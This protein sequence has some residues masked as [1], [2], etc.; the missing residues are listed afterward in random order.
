MAQKRGHWAR[1]PFLKSIRFIEGAAV[2]TSRYPFCVPFIARRDFEFVFHSPVTIITGENGS[3]KSTL[4]EAMASAAGFN[5]TGGNANHLYGRESRSTLLECL[6]FA[7]LPKISRGFFFRAESF[8][9]FASYVD[10]MVKDGQ[11][12]Y[13]AY[14]GRSLHEQSHGESF[15]ALFSNRFS[16]DSLY[17]MDEPESALSPIRQVAFLRFIRTLEERNCQLVI[18][19]HSPLIMAYP[20]AD[21]YQIR[22][23]VFD[24]VD[25]TATEHFR[26]LK[27]FYANPARFIDTVM[28]DRD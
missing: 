26:L 22:G 23:G 10:D 17:L 9:S 28:A 16:G 25:V 27:G 8:H 1:A 13:G 3:G 14:G 18:C 4:L 2:D 19:T 11:P 12:M 6:R 21:L 24:R 7:W 20:G 5:V 15:F